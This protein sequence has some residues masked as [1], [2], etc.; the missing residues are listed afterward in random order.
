[1]ELIRYAIENPVK[2]TVVVLLLVLFGILAVLDIPKQL[3][4]DVDRPIVSVATNWTG[5]SPQE[6][7]REIVDRQ[8]EKLKSVS[9][10]KK[11]T[12]QS[13]EGRASVNLEFEVGVSKDAALRDT[14]EKLRQVSG[15]P[16]EVDEPTVTAS[17]DD[18]SRTIAWLML[19]APEDI[20]ISELKT[21]A[22]EK[23]KPVLERAEGIASV[24]VYG[25]RDREVQIRVDPYKLAARRLTFADLEGA[26]RGQ[27]TNI[28]GGTIIQGKRDYTYRTIGEFTTL[29]EVAETV[30]AYQAGGPV[31]VGDVAE[32]INGYR[33]Q[34]AFVRSKGEFVLAMPARRETG[35][36]VLESMAALKEQV[37]KVN[38]EILPTVDPRLQLTQT[39][40][41][42]IYINSAIDLVVQNI[43]VGGL[44]AVAV[45]I[46]FL[47]SG[48]ATGIIAVAI[49]ISIMGTFLVISLLGR[50]L[51]IVMLAGLAFAVG[52]VVD[53]AIVVLENVYRHRQMGKSRPQAALDGAKEVWGAVLASTLTT[54]AVFVP[55]IFI[56]EEAGQLFGDI[57]VA[58][59]SAV[60]LSLIV[61]IFVIPPMSARFLGSNARIAAG[62]GDKPWFFAR[63]V[64]QIV[65]RINL[66]TPLRLLVV[67][68]FTGVSILGSY[69]LIP[70]TDYLPAGNKNLIFGFLITPPGYSIEE[71][72]RMALVVEE[73]DPLDPTDGVRPAWEV[74]LNSPAAASLPQVDVPVGSGPEQKTVRVTPP[75]IDNFFFVSFG[76]GSF[77]GCT[78]QSDTNV[79]PLVQV[80]QRAASRLP[81]V[82]AFMSQSSLFG[83]GF[84]SGNSIDV[85]IRGV[86]YS[87]VVAAAGALFNQVREV[88]MG[89]ARSDPSN[90]DLGRPEV[91]I[92]KD[93]AKAADLG[94]DVRTIGFVVEA[95]ANGAFVGEFNDRGDRID[96]VIQI[97]GMSN[98]S[99]DDVG[100]VP[101]YTPSG[102]VVPLASAVTIVSTTA[103]QQI[104][105]IEEMGAVSLSITP[106]RGMPLQEAMRVVEVDMIQPLR[107]SGVIDSSVITALAGNADKLTTTQ[108]ALVGDFRNTIVGP[109][110]VGGSVG[111][112]VL[113]VILALAIGVLGVR[114]FLG[115]SLAARLMWWSIAIV[116]VGF[117]VMNPAFALMLVQS[118][119]ALAVIITYLLMAALF[120]SFVYPF[121]IMFSVP[122]AA[123]GGFAALRIV[124][125]VSL[126]DV[127]VPIQQLDVL[128]MLGF[129]I[130]LGVVVNN[131]ILVVHQALTN[132]REH[133]LGAN[134]AVVDSVRSRTRPIFMSALTSIFGMLPLVLMTGAGSEL[135]RGIGSVVVGG[136]LISSIFTL[137]VVPALFSLVLEWRTSASGLVSQEAATS[138]AQRESSADVPR[139]PAGVHVSRSPD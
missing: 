6:I 22:E 123:I 45:L 76:G 134:Q 100:Q 3:T 104:N 85:E 84:S 90:F 130:L 48:S 86:N 32:V 12:S 35:S 19:R 4:P 122:L 69:L 108:R 95:C 99:L 33:K 23:I 125:E 28:S 107:K 18:M 71:F 93:R 111:Q 29:E 109:A 51:N 116:C 118:R 92:V 72:K 58:I 10:L 55:V 17:D 44:L 24:A 131:A 57:A 73:G 7:E 11:M 52:M 39:Y 42:T 103:P 61:S 121:V 27:N 41:E 31:K 137:F 132:M 98:A 25:G 37:R 65:G 9:G 21:F 34:F 110:W 2:V 60:A 46:L 77:M 81:G 59:S 67:L 38:E 126:R 105:H 128:T 88:G 101:I 97:G 91:Q 56:K 112:T 113:A 102:H 124:H 49:P 62:E 68:G 114:L 74:D 50:T 83:R 78:S 106:P 127:T 36:N 1:M 70:A 14:S 135:Y 89:H 66:S 120:E 8:E 26:L 117:L 139:L 13:I 87:K 64:G 136:L 53:N 40:D 96:M 119:A 43:V 94:L 82:F 138:A 80:L 75:P 63:M 47:R 79:A 129:V 15:Y 20:N 16:E 115:R 133:G 30:I 5:A 54:M